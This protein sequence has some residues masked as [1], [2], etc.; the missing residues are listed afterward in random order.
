MPVC[1]ARSQGDLVLCC[2]VGI[3]YDLEVSERISN[4]NDELRGKNLIATCTR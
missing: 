1:D 4:N 2:G 3:T